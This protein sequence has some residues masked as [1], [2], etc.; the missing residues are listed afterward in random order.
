M[1]NKCETCI[2]TR[3]VLSENGWHRVCCL[4]Q[5]AEMLCVTGKVR[6]YIRWCPNNL[7]ESEDTG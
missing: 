5:T 3:F 1:I 2:H 6:R 4:S 7:K